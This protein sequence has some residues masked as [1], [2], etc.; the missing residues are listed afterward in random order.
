MSHIQRI[1]DQLELRNK[2]ETAA[3][4]VLSG[5]KDLEA[6]AKSYGIDRKILKRKISL[7][8][9]LVNYCELKSKYESA[10][11]EYLNGASTVKAAANH[12]GISQ[13]VLTKE[14]SLFLKHKSV[15]EAA[16]YVYERPIERAAIFTISEE[17][18]LLKDLLN[19]KK[20]VQPYCFC[21]LCAMERLLSLANQYVKN[22]ERIY[23]KRWNRNELVEWLL[24]FEMRSSTYISTNFR[25]NCIKVPTETQRLAVHDRGLEENFKDKSTQ[26]DQEITSVVVENDQPMDLR[27]KVKH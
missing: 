19:W 23:P 3:K 2:R 12:Y 15:R 18:F 13:Q 14:I 20:I 8:K 4:A 7:V 17:I 11:R 25:S 1:K 27:I 16:L 21:Q 26:T 9:R 22:R 6:A 24:K 10:V 5:K